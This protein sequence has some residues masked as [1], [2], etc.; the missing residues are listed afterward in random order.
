MKR[1]FYLSIC[2][3]CNETPES[4]FNDGILHASDKLPET[5][6]IKV[7]CKSLEVE[8]RFGRSRKETKQ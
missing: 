7:E 1:I 8:S 6:Y 5:P 2:P 4:V 3:G